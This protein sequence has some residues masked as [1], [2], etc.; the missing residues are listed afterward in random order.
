MGGTRR[1]GDSLLTCENDTSWHKPNPNDMT[2]FGLLIRGFVVR[3][4]GGALTEYRL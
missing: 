2:G 3:V 4:P 1:P